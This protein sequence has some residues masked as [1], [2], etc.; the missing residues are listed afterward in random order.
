MQKSLLL[1][2]LISTS[3]MAQNPM[4]KQIGTTTS[5][6]NRSYDV[7]RYPT[8]NVGS[9]QYTYDTQTQTSYRSL[10]NT[11][12]S[13]NGNVYSHHDGGTYRTIRNTSTGRTCTDWGA[14][15]IVCN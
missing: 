10:G 11:T 7:S 15:G 13:S 2:L 12:T 6:Y 14:V 5:D 3:A 8:T 9:G 1:F 4:W